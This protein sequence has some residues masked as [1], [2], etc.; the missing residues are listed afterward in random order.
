MAL[1]GLVL[2]A[3]VVVGAMTI[4]GKIPGFGRGSS[5]AN[6][7]LEVENDN[8]EA[9]LV[10]TTA[11]PVTTATIATSTTG[12]ETTSS[13][14]AATS[15]TSADTSESVM[16]TS[17]AP[18]LASTTDPNS[19]PGNTSTP[20]ATTS[21]A[22]AT[23]SL[24]TEEMPT[25]ATTTTTTAPNT[26]M[27]TT[28]ATNITATPT[29]TS[30]TSTTTTSTSTTTEVGGYFPSEPVPLIPPPGY[31]NYNT[32]DLNFGPS[33]WGSLNTTNGL[34]STPEYVYW[35]QFREIKYDLTKNKCGTGVRQSPIDVR[36]DA[37]RGYR[38]DNGTG[39]IHLPERGEDIDGDGDLDEYEEGICYEHHE[40]RTRGGRLNLQ[41]DII[42]PQ[43][44]PNKLRLVYDGDAAAAL[45][46][47]NSTF[48]PLPSVDFP[49]QWGGAID[50]K[51]IDVHIPS[52]HKV[53]GKEFPAEYQLWHLHPGRRKAAVVSIMVD[54]HPQNKRNNH[55]QR[56]LVEWQ[57]VWEKTFHQCQK[58]RRTGE[59]QEEVQEEEGV[60]GMESNPFALKDEDQEVD[61]DA[62]RLDRQLSSERWDPYDPKEIKN[63]IHFYGYS[64]SLTEP[65]C[66]ERFVEWHIMDK[67]MLISETQLRHLKYLLF[68][69]QNDQCQRTSTHYEGRAARRPMRNV[70]EGQHSVH[71]C[72]CH[73]FLSDEERRSNANVTRCTKW[74]EQEEIQESLNALL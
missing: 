32:S 57:K 11:V 66:T 19:N 16:T 18:T 62:D 22:T 41:S 43:I 20:T 69:Y 60:P 25:T 7:A 70:T 40:I 53:E 8:D 26:T 38:P 56:A 46:G 44:L 49:H 33:A 59:A 39:Y 37:I 12:I 34:L 74:E 51:H 31:F 13:T 2:A 1:G 68:L 64:G 3:G 36:M 21:S 50:L 27:T 10:G 48:S 55:F 71:R 9:E 52:Q 65:P 73:D 35:S 30:T 5:S 58:M 47:P 45:S 17:T 6:S 28:P 23:T 54:V 63:S 72:T 29:T 14:R 4:Q 15:S 24:N 67:P 42:I 61:T